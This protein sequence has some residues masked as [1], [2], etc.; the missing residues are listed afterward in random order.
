MT[1]TTKYKGLKSILTNAS[2]LIGG[3]G[4][5][6]IVRA[7]YAVLLARF[8]GPDVYGTFNYGLSWYLILLPATTLG[9][10]VLISREIGK[11]PKKGIEIICNTLTIRIVVTSALTLLSIIGA[12]IF[13]SSTEVITLI[14]VLSFAL[15]GR[16]LYVWSKSVFTSLELVKRSFKIE[17][18]MRPSEIIFG[19]IVL[20]NGGGII[21]IAIVHSLSWW[22]Q[23]YLSLHILKKLKP[24]IQ[25][26]FSG[27]VIIDILKAS[28]PLGLTSIMG[29]WFLQ[30]PIIMFRAMEGFGSDLGQLTLIIQIFLMLSSFPNSIASAS[31]P[32][33]TRSLIRKDGKSHLFIDSMLRM[34]IITGGVTGIFLL[35]FGQP[36]VTLTFGHGYEIAGQFLGYIVL[37][38]IPFSSAV[39]IARISLAEGKY[40]SVARAD[41]YSSILFTLCFYPVTHSIGFIGVILAMAVGQL[42]RL[43]L[44]TF[45]HIKSHSIAISI[46][47]TRPLLLISFAVIVVET[48]KLYNPYIA[49]AFAFISII[50]G[51]FI[52]GVIRKSEIT[53]FSQFFKNK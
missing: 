12:F 14:T 40:A 52:F 51:M 47:L 38:S 34:I 39:L 22:I 53:A 15:L 29:V 49:F 35:S 43:L 26:Q 7:I 17:T 36:I 25:L 45:V 30:G 8:L 2:Y 5:N 16:S 13:E 6:I 20:I 44:L 10:D 27:Q 3:Q 41:I 19:T 11:D 46:T 37:I 21:E 18:I 24:E 28:I 23:G 42:L 9:L 1:N 32:I 4:I 48:I 31:L 33:L 50:V